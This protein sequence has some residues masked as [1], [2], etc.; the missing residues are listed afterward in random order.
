MPNREVVVFL[1]NNGGRN[2]DI[3][4]ITESF[5]I[6]ATKALRVRKT[7]H[8]VVFFWKGERK[9]EIFG[10]WAW[11]YWLLGFWHLLPQHILE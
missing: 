4:I 11:C 8:F 1:S 10:K 9:C 7:R 6:E 2:P 3:L 5:S